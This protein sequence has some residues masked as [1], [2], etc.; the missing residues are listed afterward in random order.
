[1]LKPFPV[2]TGNLTIEWRLY[3]S[4]HRYM[5]SNQVDMPTH[6]GVVGYT[7]AISQ[8]WEFLNMWMTLVPD[9]RLFMT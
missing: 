5:F 7:Y 4:A 2:K 8:S 3:I 9:K 1:M 6:Y